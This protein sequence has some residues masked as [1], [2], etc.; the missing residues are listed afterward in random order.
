MTPPIKP[1]KIMKEKEELLAAIVRHDAAHAAKNAINDEF[2]KKSE[3]AKELYRLEDDPDKICP[4]TLQPEPQYDYSAYFDAIKPLREE[5]S[6][7]LLVNQM[8]IESAFE[9]LEYAKSAYKTALFQANFPNGRLPPTTGTP[10]LGEYG[11]EM[12]TPK[13]VNNFVGGSDTDYKTLAAAVVAAVA[14]GIASSQKGGKTK[15]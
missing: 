4:F 8:E 13:V 5:Q 7:A 11:P 9:G 2:T 14:A 6:R 3:Q 15:R 10:W 1:I 12:H